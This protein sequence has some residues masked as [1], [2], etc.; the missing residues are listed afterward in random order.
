MHANVMEIY[1]EQ[2]EVT[3]KK[4][5]R[6]FFCG[7]G[8]YKWINYSVRCWRFGI[9]WQTVEDVAHCWRDATKL[10]SPSYRL[11]MMHN[12]CIAFTRELLCAARIVGGIKRWCASDVCLSVAYIGPKSRTEGLE[13]AQR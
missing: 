1:E 7:H 10:P 5:K 8:V 9:N 12:G 4:I 2:F 6:L 13:L 11:R 3:A